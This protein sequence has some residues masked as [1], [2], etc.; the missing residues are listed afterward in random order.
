M[1]GIKV[2]QY[3]IFKIGTNKLKY[4]NWNLTITEH[5]ARK[6]NEIVAL[7]EG[8]Q[9]RI[10]AKILNKKPWEIDYKNYIISVLV[11]NPSHF[12]RLVDP[13]GIKV[14]GI[15]YKRFLGTAG[16][17]KCNTLL[18]VNVEILDE[19]NRRCECGRDLSK[20]IVPAKLEAYKALTCSASQ[21]ISNP[22][23]ILVVSDAMV[24]IENQHV[25]FLDDTGDEELPVMKELHDYA[26]DNN[27]TDGFNLCTIDYIKRISNY[28]LGLR[29][30]THGV[31][32]R[33]AWLKGMLFPFPIVEFAEEYNNGNYIVKDVWGNDQD[34]RKIEMIITESS[35]K[36]WD[37]YSSIDDYMKKCEENGYGFSVTKI[38]EEHNDNQRELNYQYLQSYD[39][40]DEDIK[41]LC[42]PT[43][44]YLKDALCGD[45]ESVR[46][47]L[48]IVS[49]VRYDN[50]GTWQEALTV[51]E[52]V[53]NDSYVID[54]V[55]R[56]IKKKINLAKI[57]KLIV[58]G[59]YQVCS[60]DP[61]LFM[62]HVCGL[63]K[64]D[65]L[66]GPEEYYSKYWIDKNVDEIV[67]YRSPMLVHN[68]IRKGKVVH[69]EEMLKWYRY[70]DT[71]I[72]INAHD[73]SCQALSGM[74]FDSDLC[75]STNNK[76]LLKRHKKMPAIVCEQKNAAKIVPEENDM[77]AVEQNG[78]GNKVGAITNRITSMLERIVN[79]SPGTEEYNTLEYRALCGQLY[80]QNEIDKLKGIISK[81][82]PNSWYNYRG[83]E[84]D[85]FLKSICAE[86]KPYFMIYIYDDYKSRY[87]KYTEEA[88]TTAINF[89]RKTLDELLNSDNKMQEEIEFIKDYERWHPFGMNA[90]TMN[91]ICWY[92]ENEFKG[93]T[94]SLK[95][96]NTFNYSI[97]KYNVEQDKTTKE[98]II[99]L[100]EQ[101]QTEY[102]R[103]RKH[104][105]L[106]SNPN[107][108]EDETQEQINRNIIKDKYKRLC[109]EICDD[110]KMLLDIIVDLVCDD[111]CSKQFLWDTVGDLAVDKLKELE[112]A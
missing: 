92:I 68:N 83:C 76:T 33:N 95:K 96:N 7:F 111:E 97:L 52:D 44:K 40:T 98:I 73:T 21:P 101:Y 72:I 112:N 104:R 14:N 36:L 55:Y 61:F 78:M 53:M 20:P 54:S 19:L 43:I 13:E 91:R 5:E 4:S 80:Q 6:H 79:F 15:T 66:L 17:L 70:M 99:K 103:I 90:C 48:G 67:L 107:I 31:C 71:A 102:R 110:N 89:F 23:G 87:R 37:S 59:N 106:S 47:F 32:L 2:P 84:K 42:A 16:G 11:Q 34:L 25:V 3:D 57:G 58:D 56:M 24:H 88:S 105:R 35:L 38:I 82:M 100:F 41:E 60:G 109:R 51:S 10:I 74:D 108:G 8:Q 75:F 18:L 12:K 22:K 65:G 46:K 86:K 94:S 62:Q 9:F 69:T 49:G 50:V 29:Y 26:T 81:P 30:I 39:F 64:Q 93:V 28:D 63:E 1:A 77:I 85:D 27:A 45:Y